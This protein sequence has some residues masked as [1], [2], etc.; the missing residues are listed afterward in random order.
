MN[1][2]SVQE[3]EA[4]LRRHTRQTRR[5][6]AQI[7]A[8]DEPA[9]TETLPKTVAGEEARWKQVLT[10][11]GFRDPDHAL[12]M[13]SLFLHGPGFVHISNAHDGIGARVVGA[14]LCA[15]SA[16]NRRAAGFVRPGSSVGAFGQ[17]CGRVW[18]ARHAV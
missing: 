1:F 18:R 17:F 3:F 4:A 15:L 16:G 2:D 9:E 13:I 12:K 11:H 5:I 14:V 10:Q 6:Y 7:L 8:G